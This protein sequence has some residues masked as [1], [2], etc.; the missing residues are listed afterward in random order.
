[1]P[2]ERCQF[3]EGGGEDE[4][5]DVGQS[6]GE[7]LGKGAMVNF[8]LPW[9]GFCFLLVIFYWQGLGKGLGSAMS[10]NKK[11]GV[12]GTVVVKGWCNGF[13][14]LGVRGPVGVAVLSKLVL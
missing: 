8:L 13:E 14:S 11:F 9:G 4:G 10:G 12:V 5:E 2:G 7:E 3:T 1:M 6:V